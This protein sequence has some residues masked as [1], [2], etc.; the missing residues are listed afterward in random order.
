MQKARLSTGLFVVGV[1]QLSAAVMAIEDGQA[2]PESTGQKQVPA[3][4]VTAG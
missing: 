2:Q 1:T 3:G 4:L